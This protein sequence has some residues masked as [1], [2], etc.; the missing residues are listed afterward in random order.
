MN[1]VPFVKKSLA[2][3]ALLSCVAGAQAAVV[4]YNSAAAFTA[5]NPTQSVENFAD[6]T[7]VSGLSFVSTVGNIAGGIW[8]DRLVPGGAT[9]RFN[10][11]SAVNGFGADFDMSPGGQGTGILMTITLLGGANE[12]LSQQVSGGAQLFYGFRSDVAFSSVLFSAG[13]TPGGAAET[14]TM[15][16]LRF[17]ANAVPEPGSLALAGLGLLACA[18]TARRIR[19]A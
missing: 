16:N 15:D 13:T 14:Y 10:F 9:T 4:F 18:F 7:L 2:A 11:S 17:A 5:A 6:T 3:A 12:I 8:N 1:I 19:K